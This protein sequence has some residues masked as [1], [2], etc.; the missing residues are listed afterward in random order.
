MKVERDR[1]P[2]KDTLLHRP[3]PD[4][5]GQIEDVV[6]SVQHEEEHIP[7]VMVVSLDNLCSEH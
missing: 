5:T 7:P 4:Q 3:P 2:K 6:E 1:R